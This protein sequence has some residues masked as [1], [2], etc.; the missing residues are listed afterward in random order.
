MTVQLSPQEWASRL[1]TTEQTVTVQLSPQARA[2]RLSTTEQTSCTYSGEPCLTDVGVEVACISHS[3][4]YNRGNFITTHAQSGLRGGAAPNQYV[5]LRL[6]PRPQGGGA[7]GSDEAR[8]V[9]FDITVFML[10]KRKI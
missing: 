5:A 4:L 2:S 10:I 9:S 7:W 8:L 6:A 1:S 3:S